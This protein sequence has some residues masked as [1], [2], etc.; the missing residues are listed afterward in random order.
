MGSGAWAG[1]VQGLGSGLQSYIALRRV[2]EEKKFRQEQADREDKYRNAMLALQEAESARQEELQKAQLEQFKE[3]SAVRRAEAGVTKT[4]ASGIPKNGLPF[5]DDEYI[6]P[7]RSAAQRASDRE[8]EQRRKM[9]D[10]GTLWNPNS[11]SGRNSPADRHLSNLNMQ[12]DNLRALLNSKSMQLPERPEKWKGTPATV[13]NKGMT[14]QQDSSF[15]ADSTR[16]AEGRRDLDSRLTGTMRSIDALLSAETGTGT[17]TARPAPRASAPTNDAQA[18]Y[19]E[20]ARAYK[21]GP[22]TPERKRMYDAAIAE[23]ARRHGQ[24]KR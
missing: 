20:L 22:A 8:V 12:A 9:R 3:A 1:L 7:S 21:A 5:D 13:Q 23:V 16:V 11:Y 4:P 19:D 17:A 6:D 24:L 15:R 18:E 10:D 14:A 2:S